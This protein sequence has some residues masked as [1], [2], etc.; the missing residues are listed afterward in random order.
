MGVMQDSQ[1]N[2]WRAHRVLIVCSLLYMLT[3]MERVVVTV[4]LEPMKLEMALSDTQLGAL[5][6]I[7]MLTYGVFAIP[8]AYMIDVWSRKKSVGLLGLAWNLSTAVFGFAPNFLTALIA[9]AAAGPG[10]SAVV[11]G[12]ISMVT[13]AYRRERQGWAMGIFNIGIPLGVGLGAAAGGLMTAAFGWRSPFYLMAGFGALLSI[14]AF[15]LDDYR[16]EGQAVTAGFRH[17]GQSLLL[18]F[19][20]RSLTWFFVG[21]GLM[22][23]TSLAQMNWMPTYLIRQFGWGP[24]TAGLVTSVLCVVAVLGAPLGGILSDRWYKKNRASRLWLPAIASLLSS[25]FLAASFLAFSFNLAAGLALGVIFGIVNISAIPAL[26]LIS[27]N[28]VPAEHKGLAFGLSSVFM[29]ICGGAWSPIMAGAISDSLGG[30]ASGLMWAM[31][32]TSGGGVL[33]FFCFMMG[34]RHYAEDEERFS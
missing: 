28:V 24:S 21:Y 26:S 13:A 15:F 19:R 10:V 23:V 22:L 16:T 25:I 5:Q 14:A 8:A 32:V 7:Y 6:T 30:G 29:Y 1:P 12:D 2:D 18:L 27:Q 20:I 9:R 33:A 34:S 3:Y 4:V 17:L 31:V 11:T